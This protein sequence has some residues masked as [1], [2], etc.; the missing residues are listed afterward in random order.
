MPI[1]KN[2]NYLISEHFLSHRTIRVKPKSAIF[3]K[4]LKFFLMFVEVGKDEK[5]K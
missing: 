4:S 2:I 3:V 1:D 5:V